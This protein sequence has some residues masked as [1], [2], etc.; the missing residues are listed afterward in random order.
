[1]HNTHHHGVETY[2]SMNVYCTLL[3]RVGRNLPDFNSTKTSVNKR[4]LLCHRFFTLSEPAAAI[5]CGGGVFIECRFGVAASWLH[6]TL[7]G[8]AIGLLPSHAVPL[9]AQIEQSFVR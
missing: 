7:K 8:F 5:A 1:M 3:S 9:N 2:I 4:L 6:L